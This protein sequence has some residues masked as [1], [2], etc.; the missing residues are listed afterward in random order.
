MRTCRSLLAAAL[1]LSAAAAFAGAAF[2][3]HQ[4]TT[5]RPQRLR[6]RERDHEAPETSG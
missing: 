6:G 4:A 2:A 5:T 3:S 1:A